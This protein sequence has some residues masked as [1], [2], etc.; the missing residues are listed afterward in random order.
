MP[1]MTKRQ[2]VV[3]LYT[4][5]CPSQKGGNQGGTTDNFAPA[6]LRRG[7][8]LC[9]P[10]LRINYMEVIMDERILKLKTDFEQKLAEAAD[11]NGLDS[12]RVSYLGKKGSITALLKGMKELSVEAKRAFGADVNKLKEYAAE[13]IEKKQEELKKKQIE[14]EIRSM[15]VFD[16]TAPS[17]CECGSYH[18]IT[19]VQRQC[20]KIFKSMGFTVEDYSE[21]VTDYECF[22]S[23]NIPKHHPA[24]D[25][26]DTYY[27]ENGQLLKSQ[28]S[29]AQNAILRKYGPGLINNGTPIRAIF[30]GR[31]FRNEATDACHENTFFQMEGVMVDKDISISNLIYFMKTMLSE[32]FRKDIK[33]RLRPGFFPFVEPGFELDISC[34]ICGGTGCPSCKHSGWLELC[35][36]GMIH[37]NVLREGGIDPEKYTGFAFGL[38]LTRLAMMKYGV[39]DIRDLN[40]G[41]LK[42]L[43]QFTDDE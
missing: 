6:C 3:P 7:F 27:L 35:P 30:P 34:L 22:E 24:R 41:S 25:M 1:C 31:C 37:P 28:T 15:P 19:L 21:V 39:K 23:L 43:S 10:P 42:V 38:G 8:L 11:L 12:L 5:E 13:L 32:V 20:E 33:V 36:C 17:A 29:A 14:R 18:P 16:I 4:E 40:S 2:R 9:Q 26:Q